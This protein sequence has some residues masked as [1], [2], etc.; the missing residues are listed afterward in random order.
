[1]LVLL[2]YLLGITLAENE[3]DSLVR[4]QPNPRVSRALRELEA[5]MSNRVS[6]QVSVL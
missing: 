2:I 3:D 5:A 1:M 4:E 6:L